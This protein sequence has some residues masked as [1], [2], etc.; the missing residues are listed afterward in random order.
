MCHTP[1]RDISGFMPQNE[2]VLWL[3]TE[4]QGGSLLL[5]IRALFLL[6]GIDTVSELCYYSFADT[7]SEQH[8]EV[9][10]SIHD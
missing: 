9:T 6:L 1:Q 3:F 10:H 5:H 7:M 4:K 8:E 2:C